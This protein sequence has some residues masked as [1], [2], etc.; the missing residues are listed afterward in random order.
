MYGMYVP[1]S[2]TVVHTKGRFRKW[3]LHFSSLARAALDCISSITGNNTEHA[4]RYLRE[5][6]KHARRLIRKDNQKKAARNSVCTLSQSS[7]RI[8]IKTIIH[9]TKIIAFEIQR[10]GNPESLM[11]RRE[12]VKRKLKRLQA[13]K[14]TEELPTKKQ[15]LKNNF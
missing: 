1:C 15:N 6:M 4:F 5:V 12:R 8:D 2:M 7:T 10:E 11:D 13:T 9:G 14:E 3:L